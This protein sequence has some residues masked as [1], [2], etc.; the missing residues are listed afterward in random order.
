MATALIRLH[1]LPDA[2]D[3]GGE[4]RAGLL[5]PPPAGSASKRP[6]LRVFGSISEALLAKQQFEAALA[7][8]DASQC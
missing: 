5:V 4:A 2:P 6:V 8:A 3:A 1:L 7:A